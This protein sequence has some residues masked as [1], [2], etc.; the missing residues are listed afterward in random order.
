MGVQINSHIHKLIF[1]ISARLQ[2][3]EIGSKFFK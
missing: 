3:D 2:T 1:M